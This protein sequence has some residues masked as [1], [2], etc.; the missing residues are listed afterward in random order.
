LEP[1]RRPVNFCYILS[2][3]SFDVFRKEGTEGLIAFLIPFLVQFVFGPQHGH[4]KGKL[5]PRF[6][7]QFLIWVIKHP[8][9]SSIIISRISGSENLTNTL[10]IRFSIT[11]IIT[12][13]LLYLDIIHHHIPYILDGAVNHFRWLV[14]LACYFFLK[15]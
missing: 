4:G 3:Q 5:D 15:Q 12:Y 9:I 11:T 8:T 1:S 14:F 10:Q 13:L 6:F 7:A 2:G